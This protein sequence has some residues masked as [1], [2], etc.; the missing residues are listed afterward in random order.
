MSR[1]SD[2]NLAM[3]AAVAASGSAAFARLALGGGSM[4][5]TSSSSF[6]G[7][8]IAARRRVPD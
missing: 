4:M 7:D 5:H 6:S 1:S 2:T 3:R 8:A